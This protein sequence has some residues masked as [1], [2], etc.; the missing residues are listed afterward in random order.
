MLRAA[1]VRSSYQ[2]QTFP[3]Q[4][5]RND[6]WHRKLSSLNCS[7]SIYAVRLSAR[8]LKVGAHLDVRPAFSD[9]SSSLNLIVAL[10]SVQCTMYTSRAFAANCYDPL[11]IPNRSISFV[12]FSDGFSSFLP[13]LCYY[14]ASFSFC[15]LCRFN[16]P[17]E[18]SLNGP[19]SIKDR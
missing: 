1:V 12:P 18:K 15:L 9:D 6:D 13:S 7:D 4:F 10:Y 5:Q 2:L 19:M 3:G 11:F 8:Y 14:L 16:R 17:P